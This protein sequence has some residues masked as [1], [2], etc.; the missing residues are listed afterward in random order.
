[1]AHYG[2]KHLPIWDNAIIENDNV[3]ISKWGKLT[4]PSRDICMPIANI[5]ISSC[6]EKRCCHFRTWTS[7][8]TMWDNVG[9]IDCAALCKQ[10]DTYSKQRNIY[11]NNFYKLVNL[12]I[13]SNY[14]RRLNCQWNNLDDQCI[15]LICVINIKNVLLHV[16]Q[17][18]NSVCIKDFTLVNKVAKLARMLH[19][20]HGRNIVFKNTLVMHVVFCQQH[21]EIIILWSV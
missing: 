21:S 4:I 9:Q 10:S 18:H 5:S 6:T 15:P 3:Q 20:L 7:D 16:I 11:K 19:I 17:I 8:T 1:M 13:I 14:F 12:Y 2:A